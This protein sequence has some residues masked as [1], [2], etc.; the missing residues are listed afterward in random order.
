MRQQRQ[1]PSVYSVG[2]IISMQKR[3]ERKKGNVVGWMMELVLGVAPAETPEKDVV[4]AATD[5]LFSLRLA[6]STWH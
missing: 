5:R 6:G 4:D 3:K 1:L 2:Y